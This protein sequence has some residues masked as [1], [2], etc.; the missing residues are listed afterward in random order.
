MV[1]V[2]RSAIGRVSA[3]EVTVTQGAVGAA[4]AARVSVAM[5]ALGAAVGREVSISQG[6]AGTILAREARVEEAFVRTMIAREVVVHRS[7]AVVFLV[8]QRVS[9]DVKVL[10]DWRGALALGAALG[11]VTAILGRRDRGRG[12]KRS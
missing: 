7:S 2:H 1:E 9:G 4:S 5:G 3:T 10:M 11:T 12:G 6:S 8:A